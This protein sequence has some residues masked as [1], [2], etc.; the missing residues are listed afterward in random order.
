VALDLTDEAG[1]DRAAR[2][3]AEAVASK[4]AGRVRYDIN[5]WRRHTAGGVVFHGPGKW[6]PADERGRSIAHWVLHGW[7][8]IDAV[9]FVGDRKWA[10][11]TED[12]PDPLGPDDDPNQSPGYLVHIVPDLTRLDPMD[13]LVDLRA[14]RAVCLHV[15]NR[16]EQP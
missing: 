9:Q 3:L 16:K 8:S 14:L 5:E 10:W 12:P 7:T 13:P 6:R 2:W 4:M 1:A 11:H 15:A